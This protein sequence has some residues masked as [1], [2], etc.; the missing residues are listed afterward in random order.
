MDLYQ[1]PIHSWPLDEISMFL[2]DSPIPVDSE[3]I[4]PAI[5]SNLHSA[6]KKPTQEVNQRLY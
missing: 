1:T 6:Q 5:I 2:Q 3:P 4:V